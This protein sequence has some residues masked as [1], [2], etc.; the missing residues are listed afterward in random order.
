MTETLVLTNLTQNTQH[1]GKLAQPLAIILRSNSS[2]G[3]KD[4][5]G[6]D[7]R[8]HVIYVGVLLWAALAGIL[9]TASI[10]L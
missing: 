7:C 4:R 6:G 5:S 10:S 8:S 2:S 1:L 9:F 3:Y